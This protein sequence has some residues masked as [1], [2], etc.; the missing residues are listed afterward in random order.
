M[1][2]LCTQQTHRHSL[3][4]H[5]SSTKRPVVYNQNTVR[6]FII[7]SLF[8]Y[9]LVLRISPYLTT[10]VTSTTIEKMFYWHLF[11][12]W[13][14]LKSKSLWSHRTFDS[15]FFLLLKQYPKCYKYL[16]NIVDLSL[17]LQEKLNRL[18]NESE[19]LPGSFQLLMPTATNIIYIYNKIYT[20]LLESL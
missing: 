5:S 8:I 7:L 11:L 15:A 14:W 6:I 9:F 20:V 3:Y 19:L 13:H 4:I 18:L 17:S 2:E 1:M 16:Q 10:K 12:F